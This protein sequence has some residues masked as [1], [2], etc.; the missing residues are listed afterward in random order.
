LQPTCKESEE[1]ITDLLENVRISSPNTSF[2]FKPTINEQSLNI[3]ATDFSFKADDNSEAAQINLELIDFLD[4]LKNDICAIN[5][6]HDDTNL[7][8]KKMQSLVKAYACFSSRLANKYYPENPFDAVNVMGELICDKLKC[9]NSKFKRDKMYKGIVNHTKFL[10][11]I[12]YS[13]FI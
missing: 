8:F 13:V 9:V 1:K 5:M 2:D 12:P 3:S 11:P 6:K 4:A 7:V 10:R